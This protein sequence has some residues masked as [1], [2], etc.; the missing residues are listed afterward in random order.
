MIFADGNRLNV[1]L[2][3]LLLV[4]RRELAILNK[5]SLIGGSVELTKVG[6][7]TANLHL[8]IGERKRKAKRK[9]GGDVENDPG[10]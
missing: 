1:T 4:S 2:D 6:I 8:K 9:K 5:H 7:T 10:G 3:N